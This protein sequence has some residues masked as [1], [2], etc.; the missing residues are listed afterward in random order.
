MISTLP[1]IVGTGDEAGPPAE[2]TAGAPAGIVRQFLLWARTAPADQRADAVHAL[3]RAILNGDLPADDRGEAVLA[4]LAMLDDPAPVVRLAIAEAL[5]RSPAAPRPALAAL[6]EDRSEIAALVLE[7]SPVLTDME[8][9]DQVA[10]SGSRA[11]SAIARRASVSPAVAGAL[12]EVGAMPAVLALLGNPRAR[13]TDGSLSRIVDRFGH[14]PAVRETLLRRSDLPVEARLSLAAALSRS[15]RA[16]AARCSGGAGERLEENTREACE[17]AVVAMA[18]GA[19][20]AVSRRMIRHLRV[21]GQLTP[22]LIL[23]AALSEC[24]DFVANALA[25]LTGVAA[26][27]VTALL[28][29]GGPACEALYAKSGLPPSLRPALLAALSRGL[30]RGAAAGLSQPLVERA[31]AASSAHGDAAVLSLL[32]RYATEAA[33]DEARR[34]ATSVVQESELLRLTEDDLVRH[35]AG[36]ARNP[37]DPEELLFEEIVDAAPE[38]ERAA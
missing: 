32:Q 17:R 22:T 36:R 4:L 1:T 27:R 3:A 38:L 26:G 6:L 11:Q 18:T 29:Q 33:R 24:L 19:D 15:L 37:A 9:V 12:A 5:A 13:I 21:T 30:P 35:S 10:L 8:L 34:L 7:H 16:L 14:E 2:S 23:R 20:P 31:V 25:E 28:Q